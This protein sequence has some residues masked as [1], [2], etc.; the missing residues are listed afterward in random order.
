MRQPRTIFLLCLCLTLFICGQSTGC[1][2]PLTDR[3]PAIFGP[4]AVRINPTF[5]RLQS[6]DND[7]EIDGIEA[8]LELRDEFGDA[9][10]G[11]GEIFFELFAYDPQ[12]PDV[13]GEP[14]GEPIR[15][16]LSSVGAQRRHWQNVIRSY[17]FQLR[18]DD[19]NP[20][21][22]YVLTA[23]WQPQATGRNGGTGRRLQ[24][25]LVVTPLEE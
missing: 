5:T 14:I 17:R 24:D 4:A 23:T 11:G 22:A 12:G 6:F 25:R 3:R 19:L 20:G 1:A 10:K 9:T 16:D 18:Y 8:D 7:G 15:F 13:R 21:A 2:N